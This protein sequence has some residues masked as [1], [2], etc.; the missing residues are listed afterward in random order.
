MARNGPHRLHRVPHG[1]ERTAPATQGPAWPGTDRTGYTGSRMARPRTERLRMPGP[2]RPGP[3]WPGMD[4]T[5]STCLTRFFG[6]AAERAPR[7]DA[8]AA[9]SSMPMSDLSRSPGVSS[10]PPHPLVTSPPS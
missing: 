5:G 10:R 6:D 4:R 7:R 9:R 8:K 2:D 3:A 1:P